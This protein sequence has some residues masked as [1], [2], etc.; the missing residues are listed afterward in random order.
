MLCRSLDIRLDM[1]YQII[2]TAGSKNNIH[3]I[4]N[5]NRFIF[6]FS[7]ILTQIKDT[8]HCIVHGCNELGIKSAD[9]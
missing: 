2:N 5:K 3:L 4:L 1:T 6:K 8:V 7:T 9:R